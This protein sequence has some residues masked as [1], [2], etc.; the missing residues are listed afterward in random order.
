M[1]SD[2][3][4]CYEAM[5]KALTSSARPPWTR[6]LVD[7]SL[8]GSRV[9]AVVS[10]WNGQTDKPAGYLTGVP[11]LARYVYELARLVRD[12]EKGFFKKCHF[13]LRSD[14]KFNVEFEY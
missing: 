2:A 9:D 8:E 12:E 14:G 5:G 1:F 13:D 10:Y 6:I 4:E 7:A 11:M 3:I